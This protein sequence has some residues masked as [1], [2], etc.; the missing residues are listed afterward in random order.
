MRGSAV[1]KP[2]RPKPPF[3]DRLFVRFSR[4]RTIDGLWVGTSESKPHPALQRVLEAL[5]L[6]KRHDAL[7]YSRVIGRLDRVWVHL[8]PSAQAHYDQ[9]L[10]A[11][12]LDERYVLD[13]TMST[14]RIASTI[15]HEATHAR[16][17]GR[18][19]LYYEKD[20]YRIEAVCLRRELNFLAGLPDAEPLR[21]QVAHSIEWCASDREYL[22]N[23]KFQQRE[24]Q[25]QIETLHHLN[26]PNWFIRFALWVVRRRRSRSLAV[27]EQ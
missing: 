12:V 17:E 22:S 16:L 24:E 21:E 15:V 2:P 7:H 18:G 8:I 27:R 23:S 6:I 10:N 5:A 26:V 14:A 25:G 11:C 9:P 20:R 19:I 4:S 1:A 3:I 13:E